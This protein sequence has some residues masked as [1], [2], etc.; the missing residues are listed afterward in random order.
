MLAEEED[1]D[2]DL[3]LVTQAWLDE[4]G[5][6][7]L[8]AFVA[9]PLERLL[10]LLRAQ[11]DAID[12]LSGDDFVRSIYLLELERVRFVVASYLR[13][14]LHKIELKTQAIL[15]NPDVN[16]LL[17]EPELAYAQRLNPR[18]PNELSSPRHS[19]ETLDLSKN[20]IYLLRYDTIKTF[21]RDGVVELI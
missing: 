1:D 12:E 5:A 4:R 19:G 7:E 11:E 3:A 10:E 16:L 21:L 9:A 20:K 18:I 14:R 8:L 2:N 17:S 13:V 15:N 6:P